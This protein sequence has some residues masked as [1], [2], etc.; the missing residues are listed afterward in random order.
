MTDDAGAMLV[1][2]STCQPLPGNSL[3]QL[4]RPLLR[5]LLWLIPAHVPV[6]GVHPPPTLQQPP[7][8]GAKPKAGWQAQLGAAYTRNVASVSV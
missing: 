8:A 5:L 1:R 2:L 4:M 6:L 7:L 3:W